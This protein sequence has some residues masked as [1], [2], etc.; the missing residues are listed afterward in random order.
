M[1]QV[2]AAACGVPLASVNYSAMADIIKKTNGIPLKV[3]KMFYE[4]ETNAFRAY[5]DNEYTA[6]AIYK[7]MQRDENYKQ[8]KS[9]QAMSA[10]NKWFSWDRTANIW[11]EHFKSVILTGKQGRWDAPSTLSETDTTIPEFIDNPNISNTQFVEWLCHFVAKDKELFFSHF[12]LTM[13]EQLNNGLTSTH[14]H[15]APIT[16][17]QMYDT[18]KQLGNNKIL[19]E[20]ARTNP[21]VL[22]PNDF[23]EFANEFEQGLE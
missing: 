1:P 21:A 5:P 18:C 7:Y 9:Q 17:K 11:A 23:I 19:C 15:G 6:D 2:E 22:S 10:A 16:R 20:Q 8:T 3:Q 12:G 4:W 14:K 13:I